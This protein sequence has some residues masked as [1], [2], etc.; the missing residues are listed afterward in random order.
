LIASR[1]ARLDGVRLLLVED[2]DDLRE[3]LA[4]VLSDLGL[5][6]TAQARDGDEGW[7]CFLECVPDVVISDI[8][9]TP[10]DGYSLVRRIR[11]LDP[12]RGGLTPAI[13]MTAG[14]KLEAA[15]EAGFHACFQKP[16]DLPV[17]LAA[18]ED[19]VRDD[20]RMA[21][22]W[23]WT[24]ARAQRFLLTLSGELTPADTRDCCAALR[25]QLETVGGPCEIE[26]DLVGLEKFSAAVPSAGQRALWPVRHLISKVDVVGASRATSLLVRATCGLLGVPC[27]VALAPRRARTGT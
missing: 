21:A 24:A 15:F 12:S 25:A 6:I 3:C 14:A 1:T 4:E 26:V 13:A 23:T 27:T 17:L 11:Q 5:V 20:G 10:A 19:L 16:L 2:D 7:A 18:I 22:R 9:M 8:W